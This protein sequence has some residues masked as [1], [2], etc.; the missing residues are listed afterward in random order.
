MAL[1]PHFKAFY[2]L[3]LNRLAKLRNLFV[4]CNKQRR[5]KKKKMMKRLA[6]RAIATL[7]YKMRQVSSAK[8]A[9]AARGIWGNAPPRKF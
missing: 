1:I 4:L 9:G 6:F 5:K 8:G 7:Q 2:D 3:V